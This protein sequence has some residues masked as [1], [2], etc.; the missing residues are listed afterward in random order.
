[1][2]K[3]SFTIRILLCTTV[4]AV[5]L[6][7]VAGRLYFIQ[8]YRGQ[9]LY[10]KAKKVYTTVKNEKGER[11][12]IFDRNGNLFVGN[13]PCSD[14]V[15]DPKITGDPEQCHKVA[16]ILAVPLGMSVCD[17]F[18]AIAL[19]KRGDCEIRYKVIKKELSF[20]EAKKIEKLLMDKR[21][22]GIF[23]EDKTKRYYP[24]NELLSNILG[25][26][27]S[28]GETL[29]SINGIE[30]AFNDSLIPTK[31]KNIYERDRK[32][33]PFTYGKRLV[34]DERNGNDVYLTIEEPIQAIVEEELE[35][36]FEKYRPVSAYAV[37]A[38]PYT[39]N[40]LAIAQR[41][42]FNPNDRRD[43]SPEKWRDRFLTDVFEPGSTMKPF[44][45]SGA[46]DYGVVTPDTMFDCEHGRWAY[47]GR[48]LRDS[49]P[50]GILPVTDIIRVS[51]N[52]GTAKIS[53]LLGNSRLYQILKR[54]G[55]GQRT[56]IPIRPEA[57]GQ[58]RKLHNWDKLSITRFPIGQGISCSPLQLVRA[59]C[60]IANGGTLMKMRLVDREINPETGETVYMEIP[61]GV[62]VF[63]NDGT[64]QKI[65]AM[66]KL[67]TRRGTGIKARVSGYDVAG[68]TGTSQK[69]IDG[70]YSETR[71][72]ATFVGFVPADMPAFVLLVMADEPTGS[73]FGG[74]VSAP[75]FRS[76]AE[77]VLRYMNVDPQYPD[78]IEEP[79]KKPRSAGSA[80]VGGEN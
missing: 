58:F 57:T 10:S 23:L 67:V 37:M 21:M 32:G 13:I 7:A 28:D 72:C 65:I 11:G 22:I 44:P 63:M 27:N 47:G 61:P 9:E 15:A 55:F 53:L 66:L 59:Y 41:P 43:M 80:P 52:I 16:E 77:K 40:I 45:V 25:I 50:E 29:K 49:H 5:F 70:G 78:E 73:H 8:I 42:T 35:K 34:Q 12:R 36:L 1:M 46:L 26:T 33:I 48:I 75:T 24:K 64:Y 4:F 56:G 3:T 38:D 31:V 76:I 69:W 54:F 74:E 30:K 6:A 79:D 68:K 20:E 39:G 60:A 62:K 19:K 51:S 18:D 71:F 14:L 2:G 17:V